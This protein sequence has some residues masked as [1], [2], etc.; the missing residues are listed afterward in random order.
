MT[1]PI[2]EATGISKSF[3]QVPA[4]REVDL[5][6]H[7]GEVHGIV[8]Q[9][10]AG[11]STLVKI[12]NGV[13]TKDAGTIRIDGQAVAYDT[14]LGAR[15]N[16][17]SM[18]FQEFSLIPALTVAQ[19]VFLTREPR[20]GILLDDA[21]GERRTS[22]ILS[23]L[24]VA[25]DPRALVQDLS[26]GS[27]QLVE[28]AKALAQEPRLLILDEPTA[29]LSYAEIETLFAV[30]NRLKALGIALIYIS[31]HLQD[32]LQVSDRVTV[33]R[34]GRR[35]LTRAIGETRLDEVIEAMLG[36][37][38]EAQRAT[39]ARA[40]DRGGPPLLEVRGLAAG[41]RVRD[42]SFAV[43]PGEVL[44][45]A[46][47]LGSGRSEL[48][49]AVFGIDRADRGEIVVRGR[50]V[51]VADTDRAVALG[52]SLVPEDRRSQG[53]VLEQTVK[54]N[55]LLPIWK[56]L[57]RFGLIDDGRADAVATD[58]VRALNVRTSGLGQV[59]KFL[60]G[61]NQQKVVVGKSLAS[62]PSILLLDEPTFGIDVR[63][64]QEIL[65]KVREFADAGNAVVFV[66][67]EL[68]QLATICD[69]VLVVRR[70]RV[71][72]ELSWDAGQAISEEVLHHAIQGAGTDGEGQA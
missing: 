38:L 58:Y 63:S 3:N 62:G 21:A 72:G 16:G 56:R 12:L 17:I 9:N 46:G 18:V 49:R 24:G 64:K 42:V 26:V 31:H 47:L 54:E 45:V 41:G 25:I 32:L 7:R 57:D 15:A 20:R 36:S 67:S 68:A 55:L 44:G 35:V 69:R 70:G 5:T 53:L 65:G 60:S 22:A 51:V 37:A 33:L 4:L 1:T 19:N 11:K 40:I 8:G 6:V 39:G 71:V 27:R 2:L 14:P 28:I 50:P 52:M 34:D 61:G 23:E 13:Y 48:I 10:G 66:D 30:I 59:V 29:S 43:W